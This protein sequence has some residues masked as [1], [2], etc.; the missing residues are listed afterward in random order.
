MFYMSQIC[1]FT[2][3]DVL[4]RWDWRRESYL[5]VS[6]PNLVPLA[7]GHSWI[8][9]PQIEKAAAPRAHH[10]GGQY[11]ILLTSHLWS[12]EPPVWLKTNRRPKRLLG[13]CDWNAQYRRS[14]PVYLIEYA[15]EQLRIVWPNQP[16]CERSAVVVTKMFTKRSGSSTLLWVMAMPELF[17]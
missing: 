16:I 12:P 2:P 5:S 9:Q 3:A 11:C 17:S 10:G 13:Q 14:E 6:I 1:C 7:S 8:F 4:Q 15:P